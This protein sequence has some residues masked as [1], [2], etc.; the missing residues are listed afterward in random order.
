MGVA[1]GLLGAGLL[2][3]ASKP[4]RGNPIVLLPPPTP[5]PILVQ[6]DG[7]V[8]QPGVY[9]LAPGSRVAEAVAAAGGLAENADVQALNL[10]AEVQDGQWVQ[11][12]AQVPIPPTSVAA[13]NPPRAENPPDAPTSTPAA[14]A[15]ININTATQAELE[16]LP[17]IGPVTAQKIIAF[18]EENGPFA[19][20][21]EI[22]K[23]S[24]I[25]P[26]T[27]DKIKALITVD[28]P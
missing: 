18:R 11:I 15:I 1:F 25:G 4:P 5:V 26:A 28:Q 2:W 27:F 16:T 23:V 20:I 21:E 22:Q 8:L 14:G 17:G 3:L 13:A 24:G 6:V 12:P 9:A 10:A 19:S 7:A